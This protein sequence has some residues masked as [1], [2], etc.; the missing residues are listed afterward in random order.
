MDH[1]PPKR[2]QALFL[3]LSLPMITSEEL[4]RIF[5]HAGAER[6][7]QFT[8]PLNDAMQQFGINTPL[9]EAAFLGNVGV[10]SEEL[11]HL[12]ENLRYSRADRIVAVFPSHFDSVDDAATYVDN[13]E[14][15]ANRVYSSRGG[16]GDEASG[17]GWRYRGR[18]LFGLTFKDNYAAMGETLGQDFVSDPDLV[19]LPEW[20]AM[21]AAAFW[22]AHNLNKPSDGEAFREVV[23]AINPALESYPFR[24]AFYR[25]ALEVMGS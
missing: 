7:E 17:D 14:G 8:A 22:D 11:S 15:L 9:R 13:P 12:S 3:R 25:K 10:E 19:L 21:T 23:K 6:C 4:A 18:G 5:P 1:H 16:N 24:L 2:P 20:A